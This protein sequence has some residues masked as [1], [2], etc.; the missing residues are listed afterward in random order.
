MKRVVP[1]VATAAW[2]LMGASAAHAEAAGGKWA[3]GKWYVHAGPAQITLADKATIKLAGTLVPGAGYSSD[4]QTTTVVE[5]GREL[6][7][8]WSASVTLGLPPKAEA[9]GSG[10]I[11][12][13]G[14]LG[15]ATYGPSA[16]TIH[17]HFNEGGAFRPYIG[18]GLTYMHVF[19]TSDGAMNRLEVDDAFGTVLQVGF[20]YN[21][22]DKW[23]VFIDAKQAFLETN[24][25]GS[26]GGAP[27]TADMVFNPQVIG[28]GVGFRF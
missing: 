25:T 17:Y 1:S 18:A 10:S 24:A 22:S 26:I 23:S 14:M 27:V 28:A 4:P 16:V 11:A 2:V 13:I 12:G 7:S 9:Q 15:T 5:I 21:F 19:D 8:N 6:T 20:D 3:D